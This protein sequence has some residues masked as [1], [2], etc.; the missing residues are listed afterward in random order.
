MK[1]IYRWAIVALVFSTLAVGGIMLSLSAPYVKSDD[2]VVYLTGALQT[3]DHT[4][5]DAYMLQGDDYGPYLYPKVMSLFWESLGYE[6]FKSIYVFVL[7]LATGFAAYAM[8]RRL[9]LPFVPALL[10]AVIAILPRFSSGQEIFGVLTFRD[11]IGRASAYPLFF[12]GA[13]FL[14][15][16]L[17]EKKSLWPVFAVFGLCVFLHPVTVMLFAFAGLCA[18]AV[19][20]LFQRVPLP[21][22]IGRIFI[23]GITF[24][25]A[26]G[27]FFMSVFERL[28][29]GVASVGVSAA[30]Y[31]QAI[32][33]RNAWEFPEQSLLWFRHMG[34]VTAVF[35]LALVIFYTVPKFRALRLRY[36][37]PQGRMVMIWG[38]SL[39]I[40][41]LVVTVLL[42][43]LNLYLMQHADAPYVFQQ[44]SRISKFYYLGVFIAIVPMVYV[45][46]AWYRESLWRYKHVVLA[47][48][49]V[50]GVS[51][52]TI[53]FEF[54][55]FVIGYR[56][57][58][59]AYVPQ[60]LTGILDDTTPLQYR[61]VCDA[62]TSLGAEPN[63]EIISGDFSFR[64]Y[65]RANL[66]VTYEE[67]G[68]YQQL[69]RHDVVDWYTHYLAQQT[70]LKDAD[71]QSI[72]TF[73]KSINAH[74]VVLSK[75]EKYAPLTNIPDWKSMITSKHIVLRIPF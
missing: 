11:A 33:T 32:V 38:A 37:F 42:P 25:I 71:P 52:S 60:V 30:L 44:W 74:F 24:V 62:L 14:V 9:W 26:G 46:W 65:C 67:G 57:F 35:I 20:L 34:V 16:R 45:L 59:K 2:E 53:G 18:S 17:I 61:E 55:Q 72:M 70:V 48:L 1:I 10:L 23:S 73:G 4:L 31:T 69:T 29:N 54:G 19:V 63:D 13:G 47:L 68:A 56:N 21:T 49:F 8:F 39:A 7:V 27:Y 66:Y 64:Y 3:K 22:V 36:P 5:P 41:S 58:E 43:G 28:G 50:L 6:K 75:N 15:E 51:S 40:V 12:L